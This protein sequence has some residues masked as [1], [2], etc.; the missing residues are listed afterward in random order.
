LH[1]QLDRLKTALA[2]RYA[3]QDELGAGGMATVYLAEDLRHHR[4]VA[5][6]VLRPELAAVLGAE[7]FVQEIETTANLQHPHILPLFDSGEADSLLYYVMPFIDGETVRDKLNRETQFGIDE[8][9]KI[10]TE[11]A[12]ALHYAHGENVI[13]RDIKPENIL[14]HN[15]RP[16]VADFGIALAVS[17]AAG[18][19]MTET[20]MSLGT[21][22]YMSPEQATA[23][24]DLTHR[25][26]I[27]SLGSVLYEMLTGEPPH[28]GS[29]AQAVV[30]KIVA[31]DVQPVTELR[32]SVP[33]HVAAATA[34]SLE[35]LAADRFESAA[36][37]AEALTNPAFTVGTT[38]TQGTAVGLPAT[39]G[40]KGIRWGAAVVAGVGLVALGYFLAPRGIAGPA[41]YDVVL[42]DSAPMSFTGGSSDGVGWPALSVSPREDFVIYVAGRDPTTELWFR[43][44]VDGEVRPIPG[45]DGAFHPMVSPDGDWVAFF[46]GDELKR[47]PVDGGPANTIAEVGLP[48]GAQWVSR[49]R[50]LVAQTRTLLQWIDPATGVVTSEKSLQEQ[51]ALPSVLTDIE[52]V[53]CHSPSTYLAQIVGVEDDTSQSLKLRPTSRTDSIAVPLFGT[54]LRWLDEGYVSYV[55]VDG[56]LRV[57]PVDPRTGRVGRSTTVFSGFRREGTSGAGQYVV[58]PS[59]TMV[60]APGDN[61]EVGRLVKKRASGSLEVLPFEAAAFLRFDLTAE[62]RQLAAVVQGLS[63]QELWVYDMAGGSPHKWLT[64]Y[65]IGQPLWSPSGDR[66]FVNLTARLGDPSVNAIGSPTATGS[67][68]TLPGFPVY[69]SQYL[70]DERVLGFAGDNT[71]L[72]HVGDMPPTVDTVPG[73]ANWAHSLSPDE[74]WLAYTSRGAGRPEVFLE[75]HPATGRRFPVSA[76]GGQENLWLT[77]TELVYREGNTWYLVTID[78]SDD[79]PVGDPRPWFSD[80]RF[81]DTIGRSYLLGP[82]GGVI[83]VQGTAESS[84]AYLRVIPNWVEK[85]MVS[86]DEANR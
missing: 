22:H 72:V 46:T 81:T 31:E 14:L 53:L 47:V 44:L 54:N 6:K 71:V 45:T 17:A 67:P 56:N 35:K 7:R 50:I 3:I 52:Y 48:W 12:D 24:K 80:P 41:E 49:D 77:G 76:E 64:A 4:K 40:S 62:G 9:V 26:D 84:A 19:R 66:L 83:Y 68:D 61:A 79:Q 30:M 27:Y 78:E 28:T 57:V 5:V 32:K 69:P 29:S 55:S 13:H 82:D 59:G 60:Y 36:K 10:T 43:S 8:A 65:Y 74:R 75:P 1:D 33:H 21:P 37:F 20:G 39:D 2:D 85:I 15:G 42:P 86:V 25:S 63:G 58:T 73:P 70:T 16:M 38:A 23:E 51:C 18:G 11:V 34:K